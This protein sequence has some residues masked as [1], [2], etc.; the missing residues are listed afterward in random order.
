MDTTTVI[1]GRNW[2]P[3]GVGIRLSTWSRWQHVGAVTPD[4]LYV[5]ESRGGVGVVKT[6]IKDFKARYTQY[7]EATLPIDVSPAQYWS[8]LYDQVGK[9]YDNLAVAAIALRRDWQRTDAWFCSE[10]IAAASGKWRRK[11]SRITQEEVW[12]LTY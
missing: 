1:F 9:P 5:I 6:P 8:F 11:L 2:H 3:V 4:G 12:R 7:E 10:L